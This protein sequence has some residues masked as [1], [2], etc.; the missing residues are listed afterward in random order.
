[1]GWSYTNT[2]GTGNRTASI[3]VTTTATTGGG[4]GLVSNLVDGDATLG[5]THSWF[6]SNGQS[7]KEI[8]FDFGVGNA[9]IIRQA[10]WKQ[11]SAG[12]HGTWKWRGSNDDSSYTDIGGSFTL[13]YSTSGAQTH[14]HTTLIN[15][16]TGY[17][18]Y[19]LAQQS[20]TT[21][22]GPWLEEIEFF[23][24]GASTSEPDTSYAY[25]LGGQTQGDGISAAVDGDGVDRTAHI[26]VSFSISPFAGTTSNLVDGAVGSNL[27][28]S[29]EMPSGATNLVMKFT[30]DNATRITALTWQQSTAATQ[31]TYTLAGSQDDSS[32]TTI[33]TGIDLTS[34]SSFHESTFTNT[35]AYK[36]YR[37]T[38]TAGST[39]GGGVPW[40]QEVF[41]K[42]APALSLSAVAAQ[43]IAAFTST[44]TAKAIEKVTGAQTVP[45]FTQALA[46]K[47]VNR[48]HTSYTIPAFTQTLHAS[49]RLAANLLQVINVFPISQGHK[50]NFV[51]PAGSPGL[52]RLRTGTMPAGARARRVK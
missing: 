46:A 51:N 52:T 42:L 17:R 32:Y 12:T 48:V 40:V 36:Y 7:G 2:F 19:K 27:T 15:N 30:F 37:F 45:A 34:L 31:G 18:Y 35:T 8:K 5:S 47:F 29:I 3:T 13:G 22:S 43:T 38:Q 25:S 4:G 21:S 24:D 28:D 10:R 9:P 50:P 11:D 44:A 26:T 1:M 33:Q 16:V 39:T 49:P 20:G 6:W 41:F 23:T 14:I